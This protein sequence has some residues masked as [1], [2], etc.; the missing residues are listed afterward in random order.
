MENAL[1]MLD[2]FFAMGGYATF[3][4]PAYGIAMLVLA[5][6][7][8]SSWRRLKAAERA[9]ARLGGAQSDFGGDA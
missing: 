6:F 1:P 7:A 2:G 5:G 8:L 4:W 3:V 9:L